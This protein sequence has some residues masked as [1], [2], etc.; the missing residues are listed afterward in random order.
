[1]NAK[2]TSCCRNPRGDSA[3]TKAVSFQNSANDQDPQP[4]RAEEP[5]AL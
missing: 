4:A 1:M 2:Q 3:I 5:S